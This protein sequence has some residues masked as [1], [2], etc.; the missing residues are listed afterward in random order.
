MQPTFPFR[1]SYKCGQT[2]AR[3]GLNLTILFCQEANEALFRLEERG[4]KSFLQSDKGA[5]GD[6]V[7][8]ACGVS[9]AAVQVDR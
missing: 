1:V 7:S 5:P 6:A 9:P 2:A 4:T 8:I 3:L